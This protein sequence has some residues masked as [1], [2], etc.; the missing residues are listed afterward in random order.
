METN[1]LNIPAR[2]FWADVQEV[3]VTL[4][5]PR[6]AQV[7]RIRLLGDPQC[8][9]YDVSYA[10]VRLHD[11]TR[12]RL[13]VDVEFRPKRFAQGRSLAMQCVAWAKTKGVFAKRIGLIDALSVLV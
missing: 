6:I 4:D 8:G 2:E 7:E 13:D 11:G 10:V 12:C 9:W 3:T 5:D 1:P